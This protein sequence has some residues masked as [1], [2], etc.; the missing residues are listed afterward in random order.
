VW[1]IEKH[2]TFPAENPTAPGGLVEAGAAG[3]QAVSA[4]KILE[5]QDLNDDFIF[6]AAKNKKALPDL[7]RA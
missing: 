2:F 6:T 7:E 5:I 3:L 4:I 1:K